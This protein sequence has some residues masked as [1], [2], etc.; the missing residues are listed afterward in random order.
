LRR[1]PNDIGVTALPQKEAVIVP[2]NVWSVNIRLHHLLFLSLQL[3]T[4]VSHPQFLSKPIKC[5]RPEIKNQRS[6]VRRFDEIKRSSKLKARG[7]NLNKFN[8]LNDPN[9]LND[10][11]LLT[12]VIFYL[13]KFLLACET[14]DS[15]AISGWKTCAY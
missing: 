10:P 6:E 15:L 2:K 5:S 9:D 7:S 4:Q 1:R 3:K 12:F 13:K 8:Q 11:N 14:I